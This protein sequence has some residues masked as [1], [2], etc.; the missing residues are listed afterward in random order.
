MCTAALFKGKDYYFGRNFDYE[1]S[2]NEKVAICPKNYVF[3]L[4]DENT[5]K[6]HNPIIGIAAGVEE[7]PLF[8]DAV[9]DKGLAMGGLNFDGYAKYSESIDKDCINLAEF[10]LIPYILGK[11]DNLAEAKKVISKLNIVDTP[12]NSNFPVS[13]LHWMIADKTGSIVLESTDDG[14]HVYDNPLNILTNNPPFNDQLFN[15]NNFMSISN[16]QPKNNLC[17]DYDLVTYSRGM[18]GLG[19]PGDYSSASRFVKAVF[20]SQNSTPMTDE[21]SSVNH[22]F[23]ILSSVEQ[24]MGSTLVNTNP[25][26]YEHTIYSSC[27]NLNKGILYYRTYDNLSI[28]SVILGNEDLES[29]E[30]IFY[31]FAKEV[32]NLQN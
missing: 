32:F 7:Y 14:L 9:N 19:L 17:K 22:F 8:Y 29:S 10:E 28:N 24:P 2:Y 20:V 1:I 18:G 26:L 27:M 6:N 5:L 15:L 13:P 30:L 25:D 12:F 21:I 31:P 16:A 4:R 23:H 11:C 3:N